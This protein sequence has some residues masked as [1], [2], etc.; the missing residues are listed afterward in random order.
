MN[1]TVVFAG[2]SVLALAG[3]TCCKCGSKA[4]AV[5]KPAEVRL[6]VLDPGHFHAAL[7]LKTSVPG[8]SK[9]VRVY[10]PKGADLDAFLAMIHDYNTRKANPTDWD[11]KVYAGPDYLAKMTAEKAGDVVVLAGKNN[12]K[13][14]Y[15]YASIQAGFN[16]FADKPMAI[17][18]AGF[19]TLKKAFALADKKG[20]VLYDIMTERFVPATMLQRALAQDPDVFGRQERGTPDDPAVTKE[21]VHHFRKVV[22]GKGLVRPV[23]Y[24]DWRQ[25]GPA[26][27]DVNTHLTDLVQWELFP[28][29]A[30]QPSDVKVLKARVWETPVDAKQFEASTGAKEWPDYLKADVDAK[31]VL[32]NNAANGELT[33]EINGIC[34]KVSVLWNYEPPTGGGDTHYSLMRGTRSSLI[35]EQGPSQGFKPVL[36]VEPRRGVGI[37]KQVL[38]V[39][40]QKAL[41]KLQAEW[42]GLTCEPFETGFRVNVPP[43]LEQAHTHENNF[44][45]VLMNYLKYLKAGKVPAWEESGMLT[46]YTTLMEAYK[47]AAQSQGAK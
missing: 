22:S 28:G 42:P 14:D 36:Y 9:T 11:L 1:L 27:A 6:V 29:R 32:R 33:Y 7:V 34:A 35:I 24:Y 19:E 39:A 31:G 3:C 41:M 40:L 16:V 43:E 47:L 30:V 37:D 44:H 20:L 46:K 5:K 15:I 17:S 10:A 18:P 13:P 21:S 26:I 8:V 12:R 23:W 2:L 4:G 38:Y 45:S 25:Q